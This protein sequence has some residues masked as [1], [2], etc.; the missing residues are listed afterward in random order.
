MGWP[1]YQELLYGIDH[2]TA[3]YNIIMSDLRARAS[4]TPQMYDE[5]IDEDITIYMGKIF[6]HQKK[7][8]CRKVYLRFNGGEKKYLKTSYLNFKTN[9]IDFALW[10]KCFGKENFF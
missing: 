4:F 7:F 3:V 1:D 6:P 2:E 8:F 10:R 5:A 9:F